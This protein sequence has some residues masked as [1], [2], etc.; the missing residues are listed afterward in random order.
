MANHNGYCTYYFEVDRDCSDGVVTYTAGV[1]SILGYVS[2]MVGWES[3]LYYNSRRV[4]RQGPRGGVKIVKDKKTYPGYI[5][6]NEKLMKD[7]V[8]IKLKAKEI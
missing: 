5:T 3:R 6:K 2:G 7:F 8:F 4:W 1:Y